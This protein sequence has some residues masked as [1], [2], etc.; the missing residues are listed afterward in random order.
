MRKQKIRKSLLFIVILVEIFLLNVSQAQALSIPSANSV[1]RD[2]EERYHL[3]PGSI[4][5]FGESF[6]VSRYKISAPEVMLFF[7]PSDPKPGEKLTARA[8]PMNFSNPT[9]ALYYTWYLKRNDEIRGID[10]D[11]NSDPNDDEIDMC[12]HDEDEEI[13]VNDWKIEAMK[14]ITNAGFDGYEK[15]EERGEN[16]YD[17][18][19]DHDGYSANWGGDNREDMPNY[20]YI[21]DFERGRTYELNG[22]TGSDINCATGTPTCIDDRDITCDGSD[23]I[24]CI[25][26]GVDPYCNNRGRIRCDSG[27]PACVSNVTEYSCLSPPAGLTTARCNTIT[28]WSTRPTCSNV[29]NSEGTNLCAHLFPDYGDA[30]DDEEVGDD[31]FHEEE[32]EFWKTNPHDPDTAD[33]GNHDEANAVGLG[34]TNFTW[35]YQPGDK[36]GVVIEGTS[37]SSTKHDDSSMMIMWALPNND[38]PVTSTGSYTKTIKGH[39]VKIDTTN[40]DLNDCLER[41]L[42]DPREGG[43]PKKMEVAMTYS[44][45]NPI[46]D[47]T[48][49]DAGDILDVRATTS[50]ASQ[51]LNQQLYDWSVEISDNPFDDEGWTDITSDLVN[52]ELILNPIKGNGLSNFKLK[53]NL[54]SSYA[55]YFENGA[56]YLKIEAEVSESFSESTYRSGKSDVIVKVTSTDEKILSYSVTVGSGDRVQLNTGQRLCRTESDTEKP[57][58][59]VVKNEIVGATID[60]SENA[61]NNFTWRLN[62]GSLICDSSVSPDCND[63]NQT[64]INFFPVTGDVGDTYSLSLTA[65]DI[66][67]GKSVSLTRLYQVVDPFVLIKSS[68]EGS[69]WPKLLGGY[70]NLEGEEFEDLSKNSF[71]TY[72]GGQVSLQTDFHPSYLENIIQTNPDLTWEWSIDGEKQGGVEGETSMSFSVEKEVGEIYSVSLR[73]L[74]N[75]SNEIRKALKSIWDIPQYN[76]TEDFLS[77]AIEVEVVPSNET[78]SITKQPIKFFAGLASH[79]PSQFTFLL[80]ILLTI[81]TIILTIAI[82]FAFFPDPYKPKGAT[83]E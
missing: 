46:N 77:T 6:N 69:C 23:Y 56:G 71:Q 11:L 58:C 37:T 4:R 43:Q 10:C 59:P 18:D 75:Q 80:R 47:P 25:D 32:E 33:N 45:E 21:Y 5:D 60:N 38:C 52:D 14:K 34:I 26:T 50:N 62:G 57:I 30:I 24:W 48:D 49:E 44:P 40:M 9:E 68:D 29:D 3:N 15:Y 19:D 83:Y 1:M 17:S 79:A 61:Y 55:S 41:N 16:L 36:V 78:V 39:D 81:F 74:Y 63:T 70:K 73:A 54:G 82:V 2:I 76:T 20:C 64:N 27:S 31:E 28:G 12:D 13:T 7:T 42:V 35:N 67:T 22:A 51:E 53:L 66:E 8:M 72:P 65:N